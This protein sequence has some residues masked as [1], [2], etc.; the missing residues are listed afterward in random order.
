MTQQP[1]LINLSTFAVFEDL[2]VNIL[3]AR[4]AVFVKKAQELDLKVFMGQAFYTD[5]MQYAYN[6]GILSASFST[7]V[8]GGGDG[9]Y[10]NVMLTAITGIGEGALGAVV[11]SGGVIKSIVITVSGYNFNIGDTFSAA[12]ITGGVFTVQTLDPASQ[13]TFKPNTPQKY[14]DL[15]N[16][17][18]YTDKAGNAVQ[19][20]GMIPTL[21]YWTFARFVENDY[22]Q[23]TKTGPVIKAHDAGIGLEPK[24]VIKLVQQHR[25]VA[26]AHCND[27]ELYLYNFW[28]E[29]TLFR[30]DQRRKAS[31]Q[32]GPRIR[33]VDKTTYNAPGLGGNNYPGGFGWD[34]FSDLG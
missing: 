14:L 22:V 2:S 6:S 24:D 21:V 5:F 27:I 33:G 16:G 10:T 30:F 23:Y 17:L 19:Y 7:G 32:S 9:T 31:R 26:N 13:M 29:F 3:P 25:S 28:N 11:V 18:T 34:W 15:F 4:M 8:V 20:D 1:Y 12:G